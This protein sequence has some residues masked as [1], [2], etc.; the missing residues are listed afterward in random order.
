[1]VFAIAAA[2]ALLEPVDPEAPVVLTGGGARPLVVQQL[3][4]DVLG[5]PV[6]HLPLR[7][8]SAIGAALLAARGTGHEVAVRQPEGEVREPRDSAALRAAAERWTG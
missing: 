8:A 1:V 7:S 2:F 3:L 6:R 4:A 5:R